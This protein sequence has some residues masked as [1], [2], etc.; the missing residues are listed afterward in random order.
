MIEKACIINGRS[1]PRLDSKSWLFNMMGMLACYILILVF[2]F[3]HRFT[4]VESGVCIINGKVEA[5][6]GIILWDI[7]A[8]VRYFSG[9]SRLVIRKLTILQAGFSSDALHRIRWSA[10]LRYDSWSD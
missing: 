5:L 8:K 7:A 9:D 4:T 2:E 6:I 3:L 1:K 10:E